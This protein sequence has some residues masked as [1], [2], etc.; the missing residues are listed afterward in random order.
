MATD[1]QNLQGY[2][3]VKVLEAAG[4]NGDDE[5]VWDESVKEAFVKI[6]IRG[7]KA[8]PVKKQTSISRVSGGVV[9]WEE[10]LALEHYEG[11][12]ELRILLCQP[13]PKKSPGEKQ[14]SVVLAACGI[15]MKDILEAVPIDKYFELFKPGEG[16]DGGFIRISMNYLKPDQV[17]NPDSLLGKKGGKKNGMGMKV[18]IGALVV[19]GGLLLAK[20]FGDKDD[21]SKKKEENGGKK[22][23]LFGKKDDANK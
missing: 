14:S 1:A 12:G 23:G 9:T 15:Y 10:Q 16:A 17:R 6:E 18:L 19:G 7:P 5:T 21:E 22:G 13:K 20:Q 3:V 2:L 11:S 8:R 4:Q